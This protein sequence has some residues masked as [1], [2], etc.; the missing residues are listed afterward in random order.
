MSVIEM[1]CV[2]A[3]LGIGAMAATVYL[4]STRRELRAMNLSLETRVN[5][6]CRDLEGLK[7]VSADMVRRSAFVERQ[8]RLVAERVAVAESH[9]ANR[10]F[11]RAIDSARR[12][13]ESG[14]LAARF[15]LSRG[16]ADLVAR[17]HGHAQ[18]V[19]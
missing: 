5:S 15:G 9:N 7:A 17:L 16:E 6:L 13:A 14:K 19:G 1:F 3:G 8:Y 12:G 18:I 10:S 11:D 4:L 2:A